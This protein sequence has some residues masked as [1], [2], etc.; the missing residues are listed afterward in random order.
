MMLLELAIIDTRNKKSLN[1]IKKPS[2]IEIYW[3]NWLNFKEFQVFEIQCLPIKICELYEIK[4]EKKNL[5]ARNS[6]LNFVSH[7]FSKTEKV[8]KKTNSRNV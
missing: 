1:S 5:I 6:D 7:N 3:I 8:R 4:S 2:F